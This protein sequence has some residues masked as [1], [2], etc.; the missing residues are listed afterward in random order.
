MRT[1]GRAVAIVFSLAHFVLVQ[2]GV[3]A[4]TMLDTGRVQHETRTVRQIR[5]GP[6]DTWE[7]NR[8]R[9]AEV[10]RLGQIWALEDT[11][12][13]VRVFS[14]EG[15]LLYTI[16]RK[17]SGP[18]EFQRFRFIQ[19]LG[20]TVWVL[21]PSL[22]RLT[23]YS[24][25]TGKMLRSTRVGAAHNVRALSPRG[26]YELQLSSDPASSVKPVSVTY[27]HFEFPNKQ[28]RI[29]G[30]SVRTQP[31]YSARVYNADVPPPPR[32]P[33]SIGT[34]GL[35]VVQVFDNYTLDHVGNGGRSLV[36]VDRGYAGAASKN[37]LSWTATTPTGMR[38][39]EIGPAGDTL[40]A[41]VFTTPA[42]ALT[43]AHV[44]AVVDSISRI[45][46]FVTGKNQ[47]A[48]ES[49]IRQA[50]YIPRVW[51]PVQQMHVGIDGAIWLLQ[52]QPPSRTA[53]FWRV[54]SDGKVLPPVSVPAGVRI[55]R[56]S[57]NRIWVVREDGDGLPSIEIQDV[58]PIAAPRR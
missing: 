19:A 42:I 27:R 53:K 51:P 46:A 6:T 12:T 40:S 26:Q 41:R 30:T 36:L 38:V 58:V 43:P 52:P 4:Q 45:P 28:S 37:P 39:V 57:Q 5:P 32:A 50:L 16:G 15:K 8:I 7:L 21:D 14:S 55:L 11:D 1:V 22:A 33:R 10:D 44:D 20:D 29:L 31:W 56:V 49:D 3:A 18:G 47:R 25:V 2:S 9:D 34:G 17:G 35:S 13:K 23:P 24:I 48:S 54:S